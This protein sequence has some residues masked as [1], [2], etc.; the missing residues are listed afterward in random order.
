M[1]VCNESGEEIAGE[2]INGSV[3][4]VLDMTYV[5]Q[6]IIDG[7]DDVSLAQHNLVVEV[8]ERVLHILPDFGDEMGVINEEPLEEFLRGISPIGK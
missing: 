5:F 8:H 2:I 1:I 4:C 7:F 6:F 3:P